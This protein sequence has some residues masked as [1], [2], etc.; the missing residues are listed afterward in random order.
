MLAGLIHASRGAR[1]AE[2]VVGG[3]QTHLVVS[4]A[5][6][7]LQVASTVLSHDL[8]VSSNAHAIAGQVCP[9]VPKV[10]HAA[11]HDVPEGH[12]GRVD[13]E[14]LL[15]AIVVG[16]GLIGMIDVEQFVNLDG[17]IPAL[18]RKHSLP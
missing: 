7:A 4:V 8:H 13:E 3:H 2:S 15:H 9:Q 6:A 14:H 18:A 10:L 17:L 12:A 11:Q 16:G 5:F 1:V